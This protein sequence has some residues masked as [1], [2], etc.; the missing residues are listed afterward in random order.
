MCNESSTS[1][2]AEATNAVWPNG[3]L[4]LDATVKHN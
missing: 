4:S 2:F 3:L 1:R